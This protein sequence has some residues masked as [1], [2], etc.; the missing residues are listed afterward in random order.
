MIN[1]QRNNEIINN[2]AYVIGHMS[3]QLTCTS[4]SMNVRINART[5]HDEQDNVTSTDEEFG[6]SIDDIEEIKMILGKRK[7]RK[8]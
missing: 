2:L 1:M 3:T 4:E 8:K 5:I 7:M 6:E